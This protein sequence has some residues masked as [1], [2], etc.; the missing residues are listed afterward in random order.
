MVSSLLAGIRPLLAVDRGGLLPESLTRK[1]CRQPRRRW[2]ASNRNGGRLQLGIQAGFKS[3]S[4]AGLNRNP[5]RACTAARILSSYGLSGLIPD[6][7]GHH[8]NILSIAL[9]PDG[10]RGLSGLVD[11][12]M[13][14][15]D[16]R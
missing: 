5:Q 11:Q 7:W 12:T 1:K 8:E 13:R 15:W 16:L 2:P 6:R 14:L 4:M 3:E 10:R 9:L